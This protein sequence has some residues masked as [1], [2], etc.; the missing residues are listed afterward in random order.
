M[1]F[2]NGSTSIL[3][4]P[5]SSTV[6][7]NGFTY[8]SIL[9]SADATQNITKLYNDGNLIAIISEDTF[10]PKSSISG[11]ASIKKGI[12][13]TTAIADTKFQGTATDADALGGVAAAN[14]LLSNANDTTTGTLGIVTDSGMTIGADNDFS[15]TVDASGAIIANTISDTDIT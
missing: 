15:V 7:T 6:T 11:F 1:Y 3:V 4:G 10:T 5:P 2:Y 9:D 12:T 14:Y 13:L 8:D